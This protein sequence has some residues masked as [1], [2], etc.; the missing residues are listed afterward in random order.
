MRVT[1]RKDENL[2]GFNGFTVRFQTGPNASI[3]GGILLV[4]S[5]N[6]CQLNVIGC[7]EDLLYSCKAFPAPATAF[8]SVMEAVK[9][10]YNRPCMLV[11]I[12]NHTLGILNELYP[13][14]CLMQNS[15]MSSNGHIRNIVVFQI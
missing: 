7:F 3:D 4:S 13:Q 10:V 5:T 9:S 1:V 6:N 11:D 14:N 15:F 8:L 12:D 2:I